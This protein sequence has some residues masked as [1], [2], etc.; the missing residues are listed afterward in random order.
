MKLIMAEYCLDGC[1][2]KRAKNEHLLKSMTILIINEMKSD[3]GPFCQDV[4]DHG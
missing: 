1:A 2:E 4:Y 3:H